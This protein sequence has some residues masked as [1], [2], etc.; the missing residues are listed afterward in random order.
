M[1]KMFNFIK[2]QKM[3]LP[4]ICLALLI[5]LWTIFVPKSIHLG[6]FTPRNFNLGIDFQGGI[7]Q[8]ITIYSGV[9]IEEVRS[10]SVK[11]GLGDNV[12]EVILTEKQKIGNATSFLIKT[13]ITDEDQEKI[14]AIRKENPDFTEAQYLN[15]KMLMLFQ[16]ISE[17]HGTEY[18]LTDTEFKKAEEWKEAGNLINGELLEKATETSMVLKNAVTDSISSVSPASSKGM[19]AQAL[20]LILFVFLIMLIYITIRFKINFAV[21]AVLALIHDAVIALGIISFTGM[22]LD[23]TIVAGILTV[24][25]YSINDTIVVFD[26]VRENMGIMKDSHP[27]EIFNVSLNQTLN[28]T[29]ITSLSTLFAVVALFIWGGSN[30]KGFAFTLIVGI[31]AGTFSTLFLASPLVLFFDKVFGKDKLKY[32]RIMEK[33]QIKESKEKTEEPGKEETFTDSD[34]TVSRKTLLKLQGK[35]KNG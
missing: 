13:I 10:L 25:G 3:V 19:R 17:K 23:L 35:K 28:R 6:P 12:Q 32:K 9:P 11:A 4:L 29:I 18:I 7:N 22:E 31:L 24:I 27:D 30:I 15:D 33:K 2:A 26:R 16:L 34:I 5:C 20:A 14:N 8:R 1:K 21:G